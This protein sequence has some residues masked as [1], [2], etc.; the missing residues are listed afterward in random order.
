M[1]LYIK[2]VDTAMDPLWLTF[3]SDSINTNC[4]LNVKS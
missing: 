4:S 2:Y 1:F 3:D